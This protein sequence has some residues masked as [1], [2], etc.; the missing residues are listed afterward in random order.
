MYYILTIKCYKSHMEEKTY[1][2]FI[3]WK[4]IIIKVFILIVFTL[5]RLRMRRKRR[6]GSCCLSGGMAEMK[7]KSMYMLTHTVQIRT[8]Q[9]Q[10]YIPHFLYPFFH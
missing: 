8:V 6:G 1:L 10:L 4:Q 3:M 2:L 9:D 5:S 7:E